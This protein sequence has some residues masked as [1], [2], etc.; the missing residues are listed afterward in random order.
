MFPSPILLSNSNMT[1]NFYHKR[2]V[3][4]CGLHGNPDMINLRIQDLCF[5][6]IDNDHINDKGEKG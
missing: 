4:A 3:C 2:R 5:I 1:D 6:G